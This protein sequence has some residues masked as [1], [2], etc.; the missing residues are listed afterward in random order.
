MHAACSI[1][2]VL[3][4]QWVRYHRRLR[5]PRCIYTVSKIG[6]LTTLVHGRS[7]QGL[8][9]PPLPL[10]LHHVAGMVAA[11]V[12]G[13]SSCFCHRCHGPLPPLAAASTTPASGSSAKPDHCAGAVLLP[14]V[15]VGEPHGVDHLLLVHQPIPLLHQH[16]QRQVDGLKLRKV[17]LLHEPL[18]DAGHAASLR[19][20]VRDD[21][22]L[23]PVPARMR[24]VL[25][26]RPPA[27]A[28]PCT[29]ALR[30]GE[31]TSCFIQSLH[32]H[33]AQDASLHAAAPLVHM[34]QHGGSVVHPKLVCPLFSTHC[35]LPA[36]TGVLQFHAYF[37]GHT[38]SLVILVHAYFLVPPTEGAVVR[39][40]RVCSNVEWLL[41]H[42]NH[43]MAA[44]DE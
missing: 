30:F 28:S 38:Y 4:V 44:C 36:T 32:S 14:Q 12:P 2:H 5:V 18:G 15:L 31:T 35:L 7:G 37:L 3:A 11:P 42:I 29:H 33:R 13:A 34:V 21:L 25:A 23:Y 24:C 9:R 41:M 17:L 39:M 26:R 19:D 6:Q 1:M 40:G 20:V 16:V 27:L 10:S 8:N 43:C 22:L